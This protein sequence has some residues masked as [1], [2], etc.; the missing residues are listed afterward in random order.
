MEPNALGFGHGSL[1][2]ESW[3]LCIQERNALPGTSHGPIA[4]P[5]LW[6]HLTARSLWPSNSAAV[7]DGDGKLLSLCLERE[8][9][10]HRHGCW[11]GPRGR[12]GM[13]VVVMLFQEAF[14]TTSWLAMSAKGTGSGGGWHAHHVFVIPDLVLS[15]LLHS[16]THFIQHQLCAWPEKTWPLPQRV[17]GQGHIQ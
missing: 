5:L 3:Q 13:T 6:P 9:E 11:K 12:P 1:V 7:S 14:K 4:R 15:S 17:P 16:F 8:D 10:G 2:S